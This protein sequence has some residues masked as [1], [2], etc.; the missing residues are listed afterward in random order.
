MQKFKTNIATT[1]CIQQVSPYLEDEAGIT[2]WHV[3]TEHPDNILSVK[4]TQL[5]PSDVLA[6]LRRAGFMG[7]ALVEETA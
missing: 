4:T 3:D 6:I 1:E 7:E 2:F 5:Q